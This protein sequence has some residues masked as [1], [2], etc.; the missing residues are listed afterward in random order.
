MSKVESSSAGGAGGAA[1]PARV[2]DGT[3]ATTNALAVLGAAIED[4]VTPFKVSALIS[5]HNMVL[6]DT[7]LVLEEIRDEDDATYR[8]HARTTFFDVQ[9]SPMIRFKEKV[10]QGWRIRIQRIAGAD[11]QVTFQFFTE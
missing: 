2:Q 6:G 11:R 5:L 4:A 8:E 1:P 9:T 10:C 7:F 3:Q